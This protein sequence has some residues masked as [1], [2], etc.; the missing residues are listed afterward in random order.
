MWHTRGGQNWTLI[1]PETWSLLHAVL[2]LANLQQLYPKRRCPLPETIVFAIQ[3]L[4]VSPSRPHTL[5]EL[6]NALGNHL[7]AL[8]AVAHGAIG[9]DYSVALGPRSQV[10]WSGEEVCHGLDYL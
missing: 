3:H 9:I 7:L 4:A 8:Q 1:T 10:F 2:H 5:G 6:A